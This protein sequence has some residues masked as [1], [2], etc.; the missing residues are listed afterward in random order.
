MICAI[1]GNDMGET[2]LG[3]Q[4]CYDCETKWIKGQ[5]IESKEEDT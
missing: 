3:K 5:N 2:E 4:Y 1:C